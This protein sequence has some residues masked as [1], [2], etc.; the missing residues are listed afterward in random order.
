MLYF[1]SSNDFKRKT[2]IFVKKKI[3]KRAWLLTFGIITQTSLALH[4]T[5]FA[6]LMKCIGLYVTNFI[7]C[8]RI[9]TDKDTG[10]FFFQITC[11]IKIKADQSSK[12]WIRL[13]ETKKIVSMSL[14]LNFFNIKL[15]QLFSSFI[16]LFVLF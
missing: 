7:R 5:P 11:H 2:F 6:S 16:S 9:N 1:L 13:E 12:I 4:S 8:I 14:I 10:I 15:Y 3:I